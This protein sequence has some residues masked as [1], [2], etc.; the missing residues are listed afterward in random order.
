MSCKERLCTLCLS[1]LEERRPRGNPTAL[2]ISLRRGSRR[3]CCVL[4]LGSN[5][6]THGNITKLLWKVLAGHYE[7][8][9]Y[10]EGGR[11]LEQTSQSGDRCLMSQVI[12]CMKTVQKKQCML[13]YS[14][15]LWQ[16]LPGNSNCSLGRRLQRWVLSVHPCGCSPAL[17]NRGCRK[18]PLDWKLKKCLP[19]MEGYVE[20]IVFFQF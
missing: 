5:D 17:P 12:G 18:M 20:Q 11:T 13:L 14:N 2:C 1:S 3:K 6:K 19:I 7:K 15:T 8:F 9:L 4:V 10:H 16:A